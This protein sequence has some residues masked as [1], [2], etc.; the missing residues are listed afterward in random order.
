M[1]VKWMMMITPDWTPIWNVALLRASDPFEICNCHQSSQIDLV[2]TFTLVY[3]VIKNILSK[4]LTWQKNSDLSM[5]VNQPSDHRPVHNQWKHCHVAVVLEWG[6]SRFLVLIWAWAFYYLKLCRIVSVCCH[7]HTFLGVSVR[8][9]PKEWFCTTY[10][11]STILEDRQ[12]RACGG[13]SW[14]S[15]EAWREWARG[16]RRRQL[17][18]RSMSACPEFSML[19]K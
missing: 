1:D 16:Q 10:H 6:I 18:G 15:S 4:F 5:L 7:Q 19:M 8:D 13:S 9:T 12:R 2:L 11:V 17:R 14:I 3:R